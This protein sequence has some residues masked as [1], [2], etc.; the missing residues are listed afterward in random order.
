MIVFNSSAGIIVF[1]VIVLS[2][3]AVCILSLLLVRSRNKE[4]KR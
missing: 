2:M 3:L 4:E 1:L